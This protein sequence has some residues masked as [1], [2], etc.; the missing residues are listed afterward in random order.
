MVLSLAEAIGLGWLPSPNRDFERQHLGGHSMRRTARRLRKHLTQ[1][2]RP[3]PGAPTPPPGQLAHDTLVLGLLSQRRPRAGLEAAIGHHDSLEL[4]A[5]VQSP[6]HGAPQWAA[7]VR[8]FE[9]AN[10]RLVAQARRLTDQ[11][12]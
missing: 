9:Q 3:A 5:Q 11:E 10:A 4:L 2:M 12:P 7:F 6:P 1:E 8:D